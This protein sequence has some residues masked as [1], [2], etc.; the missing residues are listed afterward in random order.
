MIGSVLITLALTSQVGPGEA[1]SLALQDLNSLPQEVRPAIR[2]VWVPGGSTADLDV[3]NLV[4]NTSLSHRDDT[5][6]FAVIKDRELVRLNLLDLDASGG[7]LKRWELLAGREPH[8]HVVDP[9]GGQLNIVVPEFIHEDGKSYGAVT[10]RATVAAPYALPLHEATGSACPIVRVDYLTK[11]AMTTVDGGLYYTFRGIG[12][13]ESLTEYLKK[14]LAQRGGGEDRSISQH[15]DVT[16]KPRRVDM[17]RTQLTRPSKGT[18]LIAATFDQRDGAQLTENDPLLNLESFKFAGSEMI[19]E[20][21]SGFHEFTL[22]DN[23]GRLVKSVP[24]DIAADDQIPH[25]FTKRLQPAVG[26]IRCHGKH[27]GW[28][29]IANRVQ[30]RLVETG[31]RVIVDPITQERLDG[32]YGGNVD[33]PLRL[34]RNTYDSVV[35]EATGGRGIGQVSKALSDLF[36]RYE[37]MYIDADTALAELG[38]HP[39]MTFD[40]VLPAPQLGQL[41]DPRIASLRAGQ[42]ITREQWNTVYVDAYL[43]RVDR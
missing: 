34:A 38:V 3:L 10:V 12:S 16:G 4:V 31:L 8:F 1:V 11:M 40:Q 9:A 42:T 36:A 13:G 24:D 27:D 5:A 19:L 33:E 43:R 26:C 22:W 21:G 39:G 29:P 28:Q 41:E 18:G 23:R 37:Y 14:R 15:S 17:W 2:Y 7:T 30:D 25:P 6:S 32:Q 35:F 20:L